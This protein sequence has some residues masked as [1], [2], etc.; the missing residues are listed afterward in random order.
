MNTLFS[1]RINEWMTYLILLTA[2]SFHIKEVISSHLSF[3]SSILL[4]M[5]AFS[6][7]LKDFFFFFFFTKGLIKAYH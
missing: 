5:E 1:K 7:S 6:N 2:V 3:D 4:G